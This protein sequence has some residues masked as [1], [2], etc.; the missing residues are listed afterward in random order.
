MEFDL[1]FQEEGGGGGINGRSLSL[2]T[3]G[4][5]L[6]I[7]VFKT[8]LYLL[9]SWMT[10]GSRVTMK[11]GKAKKKLMQNYVEVLA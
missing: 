3:E 2:L 5:D 1:E 7:L 9:V 11:M 8:K 10:L 4:Y 6:V